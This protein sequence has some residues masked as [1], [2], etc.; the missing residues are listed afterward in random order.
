MNGAARANNYNPNL[1]DK[2]HLSTPLFLP[3]VQ[4]VYRYRIMEPSAIEGSDPR[5][6]SLPQCVLHE[7]WESLKPGPDDAPTPGNGPQQQNR[8]QVALRCTCKGMRFATDPWITRMA[9]NFDSREGQPR[10][11]HA[12]LHEGERRMAAFPRRCVLKQLTISIDTSPFGPNAPALLSNLIF[13]SNRTGMLSRVERIQIV[14]SSTEH[15]PVRN[16]HRSWY[17]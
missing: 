2:P 7:I 9:L 1:V 8:H 5:L 6:L 3:S 4:R 13:M 14:S 15:P 17:Q 10:D 11:W 12:L 16:L